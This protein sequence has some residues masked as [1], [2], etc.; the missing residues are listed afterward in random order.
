[1]M[2]KNFFETSL[3]KKKEF[4]HTFV[5]K[6][7][8]LA[9]TENVV[10]LDSIR[11]DQADRQKE[12]GSNQGDDQENLQF[13]IRQ[14]N[15]VEEVDISNLYAYYVGE[16]N[17][18]KKKTDERRSF[19]RFTNLDFHNKKDKKTMEQF[20]DINEFKLLNFGLIIEGS[21]VSMCLTN[22]LKP[23]FWKLIKK[24]SGIV[25]CRCTPI[26]K[27][28]IVSFVKDKSGEVCLAI[29]DGG[30]DVNMIKAANVGIGIFGK[31]GYQ[32]AYSSDYGIS[33]FKY[34][35]RLL[36]FHGRYSLRRNSYFIY[37]FFYKSIIYYVP[38][39]W[40]AFFSGFSGTLLWDNLYFVSYSSFLTTMPPTILMVYDEDFDYEFEGHSNKEVINKY[41]KFYYKFF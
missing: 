24:T 29:G 16:L 8:Q 1:M 4:A 37:F 12:N 7:I 40:F 39:L 13:A 36:F 19:L 32:A 3:M 6:I 30:N 41:V 18:M 28:D 5:N 20:N 11:I 14:N 22:E 25:C 26:Q 38:N 23:T 2:E 10:S 31:E 21:A 33:Q 35:K 34:L 17:K 27:S 9:G 15:Q